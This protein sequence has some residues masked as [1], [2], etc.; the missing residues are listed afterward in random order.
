MTGYLRFAVY[1]KNYVRKG[2]VGGLSD[3]EITFRHNLPGKAQ[4]TVDSDNLRA[5]DLATEGARVVIDYRYERGAPP[6]RMSGT[7]EE[8]QGDGY[9]ATRTFSVTDD[10]AEVFNYMDGWPKPAAAISAQTDAY[11]KSAGPAETV[12]KDIVSKNATRNGIP[13]VVPTSSSRGANITV[14]IRMHPLYDRLFPA[15]DAAGLGV[16]VVQ[17]DGFREL[18]VYQPT[19]Y[20]RALTQRSGILSAAPF[21]VITPT[22]TRTVVGAGGEGELRKFQQYINSPRETLWGVHR[23]AFVD[24][25]DIG[26]ADPDVVALMQTRADEALFEGTAKTSVAITANE[27]DVWR[28]GKT[29]QVGDRVTV[30]PADG[31]T[32]SDYIRE[33]RIT[34]NATDGLVV[35][36][37]IGNWADSN[38][39]KL[40]K[41]VALALKGIRDQR[42]SR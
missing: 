8:G 26:A 39:V 14:T 42:S 20:T 2:P 31:P 23:E 10:F 37:M 4:F 30:K 15:F 1:T 7:V 33:V 3:I 19:T 35:A 32:L 24:A 27:T 34:Q 22:V 40:Y 29:F 18:Q 21:S 28:F 17:V 25:R 38:D 16:R 36:P 6:V 5:T 9:P 11:Y 41:A 13:L 12:L